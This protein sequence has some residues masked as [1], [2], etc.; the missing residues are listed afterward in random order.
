MTDSLNLKFLFA[1]DNI[2]IINCVK[3]IL[4]ASK[5]YN[6]PN[7]IL[8]QINIKIEYQTKFVVN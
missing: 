5:D 8:F 6:H 2:R 4:D 3:S 7:F 1:F